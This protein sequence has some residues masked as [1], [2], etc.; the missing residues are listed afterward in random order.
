LSKHCFQKIQ[1]FPNSIEFIH[2]FQLTG[3]RTGK[4]QAAVFLSFS[5]SF[6][7]S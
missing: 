6:A 3:G 7:D 5:I 2:S 1:G 4:T